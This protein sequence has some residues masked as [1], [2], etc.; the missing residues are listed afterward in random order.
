MSTTPGRATHTTLQPTTAPDRGL[1]AALDR[2]RTRGVLSAEQAGAVLEEVGAAGPPAEAAAA[3][4]AVRARIVEAVAYLG[5]VLVAASAVAFIAQSWEDLGD[6]ARLLLLGASALA[7]YGAGAL[8]GL[9]VA[10]GRAALREHVHAARR[11]VSGSLMAL[12]S[13]LGALLVTQVLDLQDLQAIVA[14]GAS[15]LVLLV[16]AQVLAPSAV[17]ETGLLAATLAVVGAGTSLVIPDRVSE[18]QYY[19]WDEYVRSTE[20]VVI[21]VVLAVTGVVW[22]WL[23]ARALTLPVLAAAFGAAVSL[24][25]G[26]IL[27]TSAGPLWPGALLLGCLAVIGFVLNLA[28]RASP[29]VALAVLALTLV[30]FVVVGQQSAPAL[31]FLLAGLVLLG[32]ALG[33]WWLG[34]HRARLTQ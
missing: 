29:W 8:V 4:P 14:G 17:T 28:T 18:E 21:P 23:V 15:A 33:A 7:A 16:G 22:G 5:A 20:E 27:I 9:T 2:L 3:R 12:G 1:E 24:F 32:G 6:G 19:S 10:G 30:V 25:A 26:M 13:V 34:R 11:R 31:A